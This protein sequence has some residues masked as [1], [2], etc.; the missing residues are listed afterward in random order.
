MAVYNA[1]DYSVLWN[2]YYIT[3]LGET[4]A[5][6]SRNEDFFTTK[7]GAQGDKIMCEVNDD[8][9]E[10]TI[11]IQPTSPQR[12]QLIADAK[13]G[14]IAPLWVNN[15]ALGDR[16]GG[17]QAR[18]KKYPDKEVGTE[19]EDMEFVFAVLDYTTD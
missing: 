1:K 10:V 11:T 2:N 5:S 19:A 8:E 16:F 7:T 12:K 13:A 9:G 6:G 3:G 14:V 15:L 4:I 17:T 18:I